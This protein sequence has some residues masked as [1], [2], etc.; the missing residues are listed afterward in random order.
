[1]LERPFCSV[2]GLVQVTS[3]LRGCPETASCRPAGLRGRLWHKI[4]TLEIV[5]LLDM[6][7]FA[8]VQVSILR[9]RASTGPYA[10]AVA[11]ALPCHK[12]LLLQV[13]AAYVKKLQTLCPVQLCGIS[14]KAEAGCIRHRCA[15][16]RAVHSMHMP[17]V[18]TVLPQ[19]QLPTAGMHASGLAPTLQSLQ[20]YRR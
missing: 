5:L 2:L 11:P 12:C 17:C 20:G 9:L 7:W 13:Q 18:D 1:M 15:A 6:Y 14:S 10:A 8:Q 4:M 16:C 3:G 19:N